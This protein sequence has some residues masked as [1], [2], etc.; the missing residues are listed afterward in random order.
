MANTTITV[1]TDT[2]L[3]AEAQ[4]VLAEI[5]M[6]MSTAIN[7]F[8]REVVRCQAIP[9]EISQ[10]PVNTAKLGG[11]EGKIKLSEDFNETLTDFQ[12]CAI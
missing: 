5:G 4:K 11:W 12:G 1:R 8:L 2:E 9:F 3:K 7:I 6:D 10:A